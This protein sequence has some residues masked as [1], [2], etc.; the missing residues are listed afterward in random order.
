LPSPHGRLSGRDLTAW[1]T[2]KD[3]GSGSACGA[4]PLISTGSEQIPPAMA[5]SAKT[6]MTAKVLM[7]AKSRAIGARSVKHRG[8]KRRFCFGR[9]RHDSRN[10]AGAFPPR[11]A[12]PGT[13]HRGKTSPEGWQVAR[14]ECCSAFDVAR[15]G[16]LRLDA[17]WSGDQ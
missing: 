16:R 12:V 17:S 2:A 6:K 15:D 10:A 7:V 5:I 9:P 4:V 13:G 1:A 8:E 11:E 14:I 3:T